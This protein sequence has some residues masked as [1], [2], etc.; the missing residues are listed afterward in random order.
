MGEVVK[1]L[2]NLGVMRTAT[3]E[4]EPEYADFVRRQLQTPPPPPRD[5]GGEPDGGV[6]EPKRPRPP[7]PSGDAAAP[8]EA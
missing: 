6:R 3:Q 2:M 5:G 4:L 7:T 1:A 8:G